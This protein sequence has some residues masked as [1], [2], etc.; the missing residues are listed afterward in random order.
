MPWRGECWE[1]PD[2][3]YIP[4]DWEEFNFASGHP[5]ASTLLYTA[6]PSYRGTHG[7]SITLAL[8]AGCKVII[9]SAINTR[10]VIV[11]GER[12]DKNL[13]GFATTTYTIKY[14]IAF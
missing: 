2:G 8:I 7:R 6:P 14:T 11:Y 10:G 4:W 5:P 9:L 3:E 13:T 1:F 12:H